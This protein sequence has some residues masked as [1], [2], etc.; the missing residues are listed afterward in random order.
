MVEVI[1]I[2]L[3]FGHLFTIILGF[4]K[5]LFSIV[6]LGVWLDVQL[7]LA[8]PSRYSQLLIH[9]PFGFSIV[10]SFGL[11]VEIVCDYWLFC[12]TVFDCLWLH[13][14]VVYWVCRVI[15]RNIGLLVGWLVGRSLVWSVSTLIGWYFWYYFCNH[16]LEQFKMELF[17][18]TIMHL[19]RTSTRITF[20]HWG[21]I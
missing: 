7:H 1:V 2:V 20:A 9:L 18:W 3:V 17:F 5:Q 21:I 6:W 11:L 8:S 12:V 15:V 4:A 14:T 19:H 10:L 13:Q 16:F